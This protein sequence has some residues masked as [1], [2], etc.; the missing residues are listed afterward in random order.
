ME[1]KY[2]R[3]RAAA[4]IKRLLDSKAE[5]VNSER[6]KST[7]VPRKKKSRAIILSTCKQ[8]GKKTPKHHGS[9]S[10]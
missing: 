8:Q 5:S 3:K 7:R 1:V 9:Q 2:N 4:N 6:N 10:Y